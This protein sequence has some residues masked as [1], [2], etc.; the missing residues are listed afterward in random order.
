[1]SA[2]EMTSQFLLLVHVVRSSIVNAAS[3]YCA[4]LLVWLLRSVGGWT[5]RKWEKMSEQFRCQWIWNVFHI[6]T[7]AH[8]VDRAVRSILTSGICESGSGRRFSGGSSPPWWAAQLG[9]EHSHWVKVH[10]ATCQPP[11]CHTKITADIYGGNVKPSCFFELSWAEH[12]LASLQTC[13]QLELCNLIL[14]LLKYIMASCH[15]LNY[16]VH[17]NKMKV[18]TVWYMLE[19]WASKCFFAAVIRLVSLQ[20]KGTS[21]E[22]FSGSVNYCLDHF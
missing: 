17:I 9:S 13:A 8:K 5:I 14:C 7:H 6:H 1:M 21:I 19:T 2:C 12:W 3:C 22:Q 4:V 16:R 11:R 15:L 18:H 10:P 20:V